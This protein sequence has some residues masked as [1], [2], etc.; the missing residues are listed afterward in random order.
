[1][2]KHMADSL[3]FIHSDYFATGE[4]R[5]QFFVIAHGFQA[6]QIFDRTFDEYF[7]QG[8]KEYEWE[9]YKTKFAD[10]IPK[11]VVDWV[12]SGDKVIF[13]WTESVHFNYS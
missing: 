2:A 6:K 13:V 3:K 4:G 1:M 5:T 11:W 10:Y 9:E 12:E 7:W 8:S